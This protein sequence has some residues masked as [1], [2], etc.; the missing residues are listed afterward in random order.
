MDTQMDT[1]IKAVE[2]IYNLVLTFVVTYS[3]QILA[4]IILLFIGW[5]MANWLGLRVAVIARKRGVESTMATFIGNFVRLMVLI[6]VGI[7]TLGNFGVT[8][9]PLIA[10][11]GGAA[12]GATVA[13]RPTIANLGAGLSIILT[14]PFVVGNTISVRGANGVVEEV[15][16]GATILST[17]NGSRVTIPNQHIVGEIL[18]NSGHSV[19]AESRFTVRYG[20]DV[21]RAIELL[22]QT[23]VNAPDVVDDPDPEVGIHELADHGVILAARYWLP[24]RGYDAKRFVVNKAI[25]DAFE[26]AGITAA[27]PTGSVAARLQQA[28]PQQQPPVQ[29]T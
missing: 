21:S 23:V 16:L 10:A 28:Q 12:F 22:R 25:Y 17:S 6:L 11:A 2:Q 7:I 13:L 24:N 18:L 26:R 15:K 3:F 4:S 5:K 27:P 9:T 8:I 1:Q 29:G 20:P 19:M 14:R